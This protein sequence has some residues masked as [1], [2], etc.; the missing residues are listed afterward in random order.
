MILMNDFRKRN[1]VAAGERYPM[2]IPHQKA[3]AAGEVLLPIHL[4]LND[5]WTG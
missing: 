2:F 5:G 3:M 4:Y 1:A